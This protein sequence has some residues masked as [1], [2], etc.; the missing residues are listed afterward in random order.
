[1]VSRA[2]RDFLRMKEAAKTLL[3]HMENFPPNKKE[4]YQ[5]T[6]SL[7]DKIHAI[8]TKI[9]GADGVE[10][11]PKAKQQISTWRAFGI[12]QLPVC[13]A[14]T[15]KSFSDKESLRGRPTGFKVTVRELEWAN[16]AGF[17]IPILGDIMRMPGLPE[18]PNA[19]NIKID[20]QGKISGLS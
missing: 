14:K 18:K 7:E 3:Q 11:L 12:D 17:V 10:Y 4:L 9:Y 16:G 19:E 2:A 1:M 5:L 20:A 13:M 15:Q 6:D 8:A